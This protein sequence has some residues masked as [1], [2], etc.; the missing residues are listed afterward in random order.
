MMG[1]DQHSDTIINGVPRIGS[2]A[3]GDAALF[4]DEQF[5]DVLTDR[6]IEFMTQNREKPFF[7]FFSHHDPHV[8]RLPHPRFQGLTTLGPR[9]DAIAQMDWMTGRIIE[10]VAKLGLAE[11]TLIIFSSDNGPVL[12]DGYADGAV[13]HNGDHTP[14]GPLRGGKYSA[15]EAG[16]RVP[17]I[18]MW[19]G[20][21]QPGVS[22]A[23]VS[24]VDL[25]ASFAKLLQTPL[26]SGQGPDSMDMLAALLGVSPQG[27]TQ[28]VT[29]SNYGMGLRNGSWKY[30]APATAP[31][32]QSGLLPGKGIETGG[33]AVP[34]LY[35]LSV[36]IA[37][38]NN[39]A[40]DDPDR[41]ARM[42]QM[43]AAIMDGRHSP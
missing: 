39:L 18:V 35:D 22:D 31:G 6:A 38:R 33:S 9:G 11:D 37:E 40:E 41:V 25:L 13:T 28:L 32:R 12:N 4:V 42:Q 10:A 24:Q 21:V 16:T 19:P 1:D 2:M 20:T 23:L 8:P 27:R 7:L 36:D 5:P 43:L 14:A 15:L 3:G 29:E 34:Q 30:I 17:F 26:A